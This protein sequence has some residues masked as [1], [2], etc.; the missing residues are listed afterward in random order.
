MGEELRL[1][2]DRSFERGSDVDVEMAAGIGA[3]LGV[4]RARCRRVREYGRRDGIVLGDGEKD[5][6]RD[7]VGVTARPVAADSKGDSGGGLIAPGVTRLWRCE[8]QPRGPNR[9]ADGLRAAAVLD[10]DQPT[11]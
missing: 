11:G 8:C 2:G 3:H 1:V 7:P 10:R 4:G 6:R 5:R 9:G